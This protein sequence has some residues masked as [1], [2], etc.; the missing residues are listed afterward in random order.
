[1]KFRLRRPPA[2]RSAIVVLLS[3]IPITGWICYK[4]F[5]RPMQVHVGAKPAYGIAIDRGQVLFWQGSKLGAAPKGS[6]TRPV[7]AFDEL[8]GLGGRRP[9]P[10]MELPPGYSAIFLIYVATNKPSA[11]GANALGPGEFAHT[12]ISFYR[13]AHAWLVGL[14]ALYLL[15]LTG[16][17]LVERNRRRSGPAFEVLPARADSSG[18]DGETGRTPGKML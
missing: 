2:M 15:V 16:L 18:G 1:M 11:D 13:P 12:T 3:L 10:R 4:S 17:F 5:S 6:T 14:L 7:E 8:Q 9:L